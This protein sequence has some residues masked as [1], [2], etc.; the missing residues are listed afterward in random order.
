MI[1]EPQD[2]E[3]QLERLGRHYESVGDGVYLV[4]MGADQAPCA[5]LLSPPVLEAQVVVGPEPKLRGEAAVAF[6]RR[7]LET[8]ATGLI[9]AAFA[10]EGGNVVLTSAL[11]LEN[12][13]LNELDAV[14]SDM[15]LALAEHVPALRELAR[16]ESGEALRDLARTTTA[17][18]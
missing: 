9:H 6:L 17:K 12:L 4:K 7:L 8:N 13:D 16:T 1:R 3:S 18:A 11:P 15:E 14:L 10:L 5:L 2:L